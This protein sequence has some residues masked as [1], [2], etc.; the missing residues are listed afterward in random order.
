MKIMGEDSNDRSL[1]FKNLTGR[2]GRLS[3]EKKFDYGYVFTS[4]PVLYSSRVND[5]FLLSE[6]SVIDQDHEDSPGDLKELVES[7]KK[8]ISV[9]LQL[10]ATTLQSA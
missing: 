10:G 1:S 3:I 6:E 9:D 4:N 8:L 2:A 7:I 5:T